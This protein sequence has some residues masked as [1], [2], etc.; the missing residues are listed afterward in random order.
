MHQLAPAD[1]APAQP[2]DISFQVDLPHLRDA[3]KAVSSIER[4]GTFTF[5]IAADEARLLAGHSIAVVA[6]VPIVNLSGLV[7]PNE[8]HLDLATS[9]LSALG[10]GDLDQHGLISLRAARMEAGFTGLL[11]L[12]AGF[13]VMWPYTVTAV[14]ESS[15]EVDP[16]RGV[17]VD[18]RTIRSALADV[19]DFAGEDDWGG[20]R[21][22]TLQIAGS[23]ALGMSRLACQSIISDDLAKVELRVASPSSKALSAV[24]AQLRSAETKLAT[25]VD[26]QVLSDTYL[27]V[28][29]P[30]APP[31]PDWPERNEPAAQVQTEV[32]DLMDAIDA[33]S[34]QVQDANPLVTLQVNEDAEAFT[35]STVVPGGQAVALCP[36]APANRK[37]TGPIELLFN[38]GALSKFRSRMQEAAQIRVYDHF[39]EIHQTSSTQQ[40]KTLVSLERRSS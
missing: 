24:L 31:P 32:A 7:A 10:N 6:R 1:V 26:T 13:E 18:P 37:Q 8:L 19:R 9:S 17:P 3:W 2:C 39:I 12:S 21:L 29:I 14:R 30:T 34:C 27:K 11:E 16:I 25:I 36:I 33:I 40:R 28:T 38:A 20:H 5:V 23:E 22:S 35:L 15:V 4:D